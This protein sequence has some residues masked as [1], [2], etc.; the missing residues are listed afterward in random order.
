MQYY[1][2]NPTNG[3]SHFLDIDIGDTFQWYALTAYKRGILDG[4]YAQPNRLLSKADFIELLVK[5]GKFEKNPS[6]LKIYKDTTAMNLKFQYIQDY[7]FKIRAKWGNFYPDTLLTRQ[8]VL[9]ILGNII[10]KEPIKK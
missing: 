8:W 6:Q 1:G 4:N 2:I 7:A 10:A 3:T 9:D 5:I